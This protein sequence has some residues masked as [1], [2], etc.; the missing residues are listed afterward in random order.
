MVSKINRNPKYSNVSGHIIPFSLK[1][2]PCQIQINSCTVVDGSFS[3][4]APS[5]FDYYGYTDIEYALLDRKGYK[6]AWLES[7]VGS[8]IKE[9]IHAEILNYAKAD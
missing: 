7:K 5:D 3:H 1:G 4:D 2:I 6:A 9:Q 8:E